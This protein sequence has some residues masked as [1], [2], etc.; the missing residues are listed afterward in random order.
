MGKYKRAGET[1]RKTR[2]KMHKSGKNWV[3]TLI[4]QIGLMHFLG[5]SISE[6][7]INVDVYEQKNISASTILKGVAALGA[8]TGA[9]VVSGNVFADETVLAKETTLTTT[10]GNEVKLSSENF[11]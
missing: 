3:R 10:D 1:S 11:T 7:K 4:S 6:K 2:V 9:T 5:G 8:L